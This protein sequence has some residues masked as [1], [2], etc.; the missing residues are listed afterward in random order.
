MDEAGFPAFVR[1]QSKARGVIKA[2]VVN[3]YTSTHI[4]GV[5]KL[6][7]LPLAY[8]RIVP[9]SSQAIKGLKSQIDERA[10]EKERMAEDERAFEAMWQEEHVLRLQRE[11]KELE[12]R[13]RKQQEARE[14][15]RSQVRQP[16]R[17]FYLW[18]VDTYNS[19]DAGTRRQ[20]TKRD[21]ND[22]AAERSPDRKTKD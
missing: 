1:H 12:E 20:T 9:P 22:K 6:S 5:Y 19:V 2:R 13:I 18:A 17:L 10:K 7:H 14:N 16:G 15:I 4:G 11:H 21:G 3:Q 8:T